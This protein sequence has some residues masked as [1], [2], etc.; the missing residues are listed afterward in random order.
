MKFD[1]PFEVVGMFDVLEHLPDDRRALQDVRRVLAPTGRLLLTV[2]AHMALWS[3]TDEF[4]NH[5]RRYSVAQLRQALTESGYRVEF[6]SE[7]MMALVPFMWLNRRAAS[8]L[9]R[10]RG[11]PV[12]DAKSL[13]LSELRI[14]P[15]FNRIMSWLLGWEARLLARRRPL[16]FGASIIALACRDDVAPASGRQAA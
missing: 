8:M 3:H 6:A 12:P 4:A 10:L 2:P 1:A 13:A 14:V 9:R 7:F 16:P 11:G 15:G 5:Y